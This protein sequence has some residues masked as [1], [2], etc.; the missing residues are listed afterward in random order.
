MTGKL[1][2][3]YWKKEA[4]SLLQQQ[5]LQ[6]PGLLISHD[7]FISS[8]LNPSSP[9]KLRITD[10]TE[11][12][13]LKK[14]YRKQGCK[15][16]RHNEGGVPWSRKTIPVPSECSQTKRATL[17]LRTIGFQMP[18]ELPQGGYIGSISY[19]RRKS[20][21]K[22]AAFPNCE[23]AWFYICTKEKRC[24]TRTVPGCHHEGLACRYHKCCIYW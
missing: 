21:G 22:L 3:L 7:G 6:L 18:I 15:S 23:I 10:Q 24:N 17:L 11:T 9:V 4:M 20:T 5:G 8:I 14:V 13:R 2:L 12:R 19:I 16:R 1:L